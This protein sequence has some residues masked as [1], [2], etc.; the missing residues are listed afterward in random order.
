MGV[1]HQK[2]LAGVLLDLPI[3]PLLDDFL[4]PGIFVFGLQIV[5]S[6]G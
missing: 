6:R 1:H 4:H 2:V 5:D 3:Q